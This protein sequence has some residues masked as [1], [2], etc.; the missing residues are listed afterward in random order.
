MKEL[1]EAIFNCEVDFQ[2]SRLERGCANHVGVNRFSDDDL[3][4]I[5]AL[6]NR[7]DVKKAT[8]PKK[9]EVFGKPPRAPPVEVQAALEEYVSTL[10]P[11]CGKD[12]VTPWW[13]RL[14]SAGRDN[15]GCTALMVDDPDATTA[16]FTLFAK[17]QPVQVEF[18]ELRLAPHAVVEFTEDLEDAW[19]APD[20]RRELFFWTP[21][22]SIKRRTCLSPTIPTFLSSTTSDLKATVWLGITP[23]LTSWTSCGVSQLP[24]WPR[25]RRTRGI[26]IRCRLIRFK[27]FS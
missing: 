27:R 22:V 3:N 6:L 17:E 15:W 18:L 24:P 13:A 5:L 4:E 2:A 11:S 19:W 10:G 14:V 16:Y 26:H 7:D 21:C 23:P 12:P 9:A 8:M 20:H 25:L 1:E